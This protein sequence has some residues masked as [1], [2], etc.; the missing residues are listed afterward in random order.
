VLV[1]TLTKRMAEDLTEYYRD[2]GVRVEYLHADVETLDR[3]RILR[4]KRAGNATHQRASPRL[5]GRV[6]VRGTSIR[7]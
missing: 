3:V 2:L 5:S 7:H 6:V 4:G 1:T